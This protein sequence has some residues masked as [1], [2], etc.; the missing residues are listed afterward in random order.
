M[1]IA[2]PPASTPAL[3]DRSTRLMLFGIFQIV[4][5]CLCGLMGLMMLVGSV[6]GPMARVPQGEAINAQSMIPA[7]AF[8]L[9]LAVAF[10]WL[11]V[12]SIRAR[13]WAWT[14]TV[15][16]SW[17][18][19]IVGV[20][21]FAAF[22]LF[23]GPIMSAAMEQ[24]AKMP[25]QALL[26][27][28]IIAG[29]VVACIYILLPAIFLIFYHRES[30]RATC[31][32]R[33]PQIRWTDRCPMPVLALSILLALSVVSMPSALVYGPV[34][35]LFGV[36]VSGPAGAAVILLVTAAMAYFAWGT[37]RLQM[38]A[39]WGMLLL[40]IVGA[41]NGVVT[42][43]RTDLMEM[44]EKM[45]IPAA[46]LEMM[47]KSGMIETMS[48]W[49]PWMGLVGG[50]VWLGYLLYVRRYFVRNAAEALGDNRSSREA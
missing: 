49:M 36:F 2:Q 37:Y 44:Y 17:M 3:P 11:G 23:A 35:P 27:I 8:Y 33:D 48:R 14:L 16:L 31:L 47:R 20:V 12:G 10:I 5:G 38:A 41:L 29:A 22:V 21:G 18:W 39:W 28:Q 43:S 13:R 50:A 45:R 19:L 32:R 9:V 6:L 30:V 4:L 46:Q 15:V 40:G 7:I 24:Q 42:F 26:V 1:S 34:M 25:P